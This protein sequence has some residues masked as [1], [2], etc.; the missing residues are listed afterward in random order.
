MGYTLP[1]FI[2]QADLYRSDG[3]GGLDY[4]VRF[5]CCLAPGR[6]VNLWSGPILETSQLT[7]GTY[8]LVQRD[9]DIRD[10]RNG[11]ADI[12]ALPFTGGAFYVVWGVVEVGAGWPN[13]YRRVVMC[14]WQFQWAE[15]YPILP[16]TH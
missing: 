15:P 7:V 2:L 1:Q 14:P 13:H 3:A 11:I 12:V 16:N 5:P 9:L 8:L 4:I 6:R 10:G